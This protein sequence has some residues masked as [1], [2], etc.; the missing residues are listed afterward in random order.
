MGR[1]AK[2]NLVHVHANVHV[3]WHVKGVAKNLTFYILSSLYL[4]LR[5]SDL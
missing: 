5:A 1:I 4:W 3:Q 2:A